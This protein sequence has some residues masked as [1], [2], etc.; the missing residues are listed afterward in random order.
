MTTELEQEALKWRRTAA[1]FTQHV[2]AELQSAGGDLLR[3]DHPSIKIAVA[4]ASRLST[5]S[6]KRGSATWSRQLLPDLR[7]NVVHP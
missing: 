7:E 4:A 3:A 2:D 1:D 5:G 6:V